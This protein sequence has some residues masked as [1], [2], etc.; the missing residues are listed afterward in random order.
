[1]EYRGALSAKSPFGRLN[2]TKGIHMLSRRCTPRAKR[3]VGSLTKL[4]RPK[5][6]PKPL[7]KA[8]RTAK[9]KQQWTLTPSST[10]SP[11]R[12]RSH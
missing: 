7:T 9:Y 6:R 3:T 5:R 8:S 1:M 4:M 2:P 11:P 12:K 10:S